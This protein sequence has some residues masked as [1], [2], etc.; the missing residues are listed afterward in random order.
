MLREGFLRDGGDFVDLGDWGGMFMKIERF[1][2]FLV[3]EAN[4]FYL[5]QLL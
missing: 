5:N 3:L 2:N 1:E 4:P